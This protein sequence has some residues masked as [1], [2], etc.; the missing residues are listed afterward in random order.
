MSM[1]SFKPVLVMG[2]F[3]AAVLA[4]ATFGSAVGER[5]KQD[6]D[7]HENPVKVPT[8]AGTVVRC[9]DAPRIPEDNPQVW[10][11]RTKTTVTVGW[12]GRGWPEFTVRLDD[13]TCRDRPDLGQW[14]RPVGPFPRF[15]DARI[16]KRPGEDRAYVGYTLFGDGEG[17]IARLEDITAVRP[18]GRSIDWKHQTATGGSAEIGNMDGRQVVRAVD[19]ECTDGVCGDADY[20]DARDVQVGETVRVTFRFL[21]IPDDWDG[22]SPLEAKQVVEVPFKVVSESRTG[23]AEPR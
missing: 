10:V 1:S 13:P 12:A 17:L 19:G 5:S 8:T 16:V 6:T 14:L 23:S 2:A 11:R 22:E 7:G 18:D 21:D 4:S 9:Q 20:F 15:D 3:L